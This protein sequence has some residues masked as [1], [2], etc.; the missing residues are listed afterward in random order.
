V[1]RL[2]DCREA[3]QPVWLRADAMAQEALLYHRVST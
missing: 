1:V 3:G 2:F